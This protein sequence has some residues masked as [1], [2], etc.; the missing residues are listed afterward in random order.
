MSKISVIIPTHNRIAMVKEAIESVRRQHNVTMEILVV[1]DCSTDET[2]K[3][4]MSEQDI[5][6]INNTQPGNAGLN[7]QK[8]YQ[9]ATGDYVAF[10]DDDDFY[11]DDDFFSHAISHL[12]EDQTLVAVTSNAIIWHV[13][14]DKKTDHSLPLQ[15]K[16]SG[17]EYLNE[18]TLKYPK[19]WSTFTTVFRKSMLDQA[20]FNE[21]KMM[22]DTSIYL[23]ALCM[24]D[25]VFLKEIS[26]VYR[27]H[28][29]N[30]SKRM[31]IAFIIANLD[32]K[33]RI[34]DLIKRMNIVLS[35]DWLN[36]QLFTTIKYYIKESKPAKIDLYRLISWI[37]RNRGINGLLISLKSLRLAVKFR[38][39]QPKQQ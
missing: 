21:M 4:L 10:L 37:L 25:I 14:E 39:N 2:G 9:L 8:A 18:F 23:R 34:Y 30:I 20:G 24:G 32:E 29:Q 3:Q 12:D 19:P 26:G 33:M 27:V 11:T 17:R 35:S 28:S 22:N 15:G 7:R 1:N 38:G 6:L 31:D 5:R 36:Q 13:D 16:V